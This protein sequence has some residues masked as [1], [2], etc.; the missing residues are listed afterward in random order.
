MHTPVLL[1]KVIEKL[2]IKTGGFYI[3]ATFGEG[4]YSQEV[5]KKGGNVLAIEIDE[6]QIKNF[7]KKVKNLKIVHGNFS[8]IEIIAKNND[9][10]PV[11]GVIFDLGLSMRQLTDSK[12]GFSY[13]ALDDDLDMRLDVN[14]SLKASDLIKKTNVFDLAEIFSKYSEELKSKEI[15]L[16]IKKTKKMNKVKDLILAID[17]A[18]GYKSEKTYARIFQALRIAVNNEFENLKKGLSGALKILKKGGRIVIVSFHSLE[19]RI[20]KNFVVENNLKFLD[21]KPVFGIKSFERSAKLR[22][23]II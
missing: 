3:D 16:E 4:G 22:T 10:F 19:D 9:F 1:Q 7:K 8:D 17:K 23:I 14:L 6:N 21:K 5:I 20:V 15:A 2:D 13:K 18:L 12:R 11:D